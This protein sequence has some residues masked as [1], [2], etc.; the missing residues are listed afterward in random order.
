MPPRLFPLPRVL[1]ERGGEGAPADAPI[2]HE[3]DASLPPQGYALAIGDGKLRLAASDASGHRYGEETLADLRAQTRGVLPALEIRDWPELAVR[4]FMLDVSRDRMPTRATLERFVDLLARLRMNHLELYV[5]HAFAYRDHE[6]VWRDASPLTPDD[7]RWLDSLCAGRGIELAANQ[8]CFG[9][10]E[11]WLRHARYRERAE[12]PDGFELPGL[13]RRSP[14]VLAPTAENAAFALGLMRELMQ[15]LKSRRVH[16]GCDETFELGRGKSRDD[17]AVRG[18]GRVYFDHLMRLM[19]PLRA[20]GCEVLFWGDIVRAH[21]ELVP[22]LPREGLVALAWHYE[23]PQDPASLPDAVREIAARFGMTDEVLRGFSGVLRPFAEAG[24]P[25]WVCPGTSSWNSLVGRWPNARANCLDA[26]EQ[27]AAHGAQGFLVTD[28]GDHGHLQ[29]PSVS[30]APLLYAAAVAWNPAAHRDLDVAAA[31]DAHVF[32]DE[33]RVL[34]ALC[35]AI[36]AAGDATGVRALN[37]S[38]LFA[39]LVPSANV[40]VFGRGDAAQLARVAAS[41]DAARERLVDARPRCADADT[42]VRELAQAIRLARHGAWRMLR[43][44]GG[45]APSD[46]ASRR[47]LE[48]AVEEQRACWRL[49]SREGGLADSVARLEATL[50]LYTDG[51]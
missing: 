10:L 7:L 37:A 15:N 17:V 33:A 8:N 49:R 46:A 14:A 28:W 51:R 36:G 34:G 5:E 18:R 35:E 12:A 24:R 16:I 43:E 30:F 1:R 13:G 20:E 25:F 29:P 47:D 23:A 32:A 40:S 21:A 41:L 22:E 38:P 50:A 44:A 11:R 42:V 2:L 45:A 3:R 31:L 9:H 6:E 26:A 39:A 4:G 19:E 27:G 48:E